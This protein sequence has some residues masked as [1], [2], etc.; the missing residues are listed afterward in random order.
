MVARCLIQTARELAPI[1]SLSVFIITGGS[2][3][4]MAS[5]S[6]STF[7]RQAFCKANRPKGAKVGVDRIR[8]APAQDFSR[9]PV[10]DH[11]E[12]ME[13]IA[14]RNQG[15]AGGPLRGNTCLLL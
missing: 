9:D 13:S 14:H 11:D 2:N 4:V 12:E 3:L 7:A 6:V 1:E 8:K 5:L 10:R 15:D